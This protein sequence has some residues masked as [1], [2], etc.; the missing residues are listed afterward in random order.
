MPKN[1]SIKKIINFVDF[2]GIGTITTNNYEVRDVMVFGYFK[3]ERFWFIVNSDINY[4]DYFIV[5]EASTGARLTNYCYPTIEMAL[6]QTLPY[7]K[8]HYIRFPT[9]VGNYLVRLKRNL[10]SRN[11]VNL[12]TL[13]IDSSLWNL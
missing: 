2:N 6:E 4:P 5:T 7:I 3:Y 13:A 10:L 12:S 11:T 9:T 8:D 1:Q